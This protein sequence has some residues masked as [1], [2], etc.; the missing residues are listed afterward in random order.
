VLERLARWRV[1]FGFALGVVVFVFA[2]P[3]MR[4]LVWG[5]AVA[6]SGEALRIWAAGHLNKG[7]EVTASGPYRWLAHPLYVGSSIMALGLALAS[8]S[9]FV[10]VLIVGYLAVM[11]TAAVRSEEASLRRAFGNRYDRYR[12]GAA[13]PARRFSLAQARANHEH[14]TVAGLV[15]ALLLLLVKATYN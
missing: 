15:L 6:L 12:Q 2:R 5:G 7:R 1:P 13:D 4:S 8:R 14:R 3:T 10:V 9:T 11:I